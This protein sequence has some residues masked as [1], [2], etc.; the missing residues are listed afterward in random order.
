MARLVQQ[1][2]ERLL[3]PEGAC[4]VTFQTASE[5]IRNGWHV[6]RTEPATEYEWHHY[7]SGVTEPLSAEDEAWLREWGRT[8][9]VH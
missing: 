3:P 4:I 9:H 5:R 8:F 6:C 7:E 2:R 1:G